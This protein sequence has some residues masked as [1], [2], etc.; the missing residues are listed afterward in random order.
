MICTISR[1]AIAITGA[2]AL[3]GCGEV[4]F[5]RGS[6]PDAFA[7]ARASCRDQNADPAAVRACLSHAGWNVTDLD[8]GPAAE[9]PAPAAQSSPEAA[10][11]TPPMPPTASAPAAPLPASPAP[12]GK[13]AIGSWWKFG[14]GAADLQATADACAAGLGPDDRPDAGY[15]LVTR[16]LYACLHDHGWHGIGRGAS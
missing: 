16:A 9:K 15:H 8:A 2:L 14:A 7:A 5:K 10:T 1:A 6:G 11:N 13:L 4:A 12:P 3:S